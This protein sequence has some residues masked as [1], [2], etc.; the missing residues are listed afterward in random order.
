[1]TGGFLFFLTKKKIKELFNPIVTNSISQNFSHFLDTILT[2]L[3]PDLS[4]QYESG[5][6]GAISVRIHMDPDQKHWLKGTYNTVPD[7]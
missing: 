2:V 5:S 7:R 6:R 4:S 1:M 3:D